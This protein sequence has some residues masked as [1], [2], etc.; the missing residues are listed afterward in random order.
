MIDAGLLKLC[1]LEEL[2]L[3][4]N[5]L[6]EVPSE[7]LPPR[8]TVL[9]LRN[10][11][12]KSLSA[13]TSHPPPRLLY[14]GL[15]SNPLGSLVDVS[16]LTGAHWPALVCLDLSCCDFEDQ[17]VLLGGLSSLPR[18]RSLLLEGTPCSLSRSYPGLTLDLLQQLTCLDQQWISP[19]ERQSFRGMGRLSGRDAVREC[20]R[21]TVHV[22]RLRG[23]PDPRQDRD[24]G[25]DFPLL[26]FSYQVSYD[27]ISHA[28][29]P[30]SI[31]SESEA[32]ADVA[33]ALESGQSRE[34]EDPCVLSSHSSSKLVWSESM[35]FSDSHSHSVWDLR[36]L[37]SFLSQGMCVRV[38]EEKILSWP[39]VSEDTATPKPGAKGAKAKD[40]PPTPA[41]TKGK[42]KKKRAV[43]ELVQDPPVRRE[44]GSLHVPLHSLLRRGHK[45][46]LCC[47]FGPLHSG[48]PTPEHATGKDEGKKGKKDKKE[49][50][51]KGESAKKTA[52][53][54]GKEKSV[55][56]EADVG[57]SGPQ[58][59]L[60]VELSVQLE[61]W[62]STAEVRDELG[63][64]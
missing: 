36:T 8:L 42:E 31:R 28:H 47:D 16:S 53:A 35:D 22:G 38:H 17:R 23:L 10:N 4:A 26:S 64:N 58:E 44:L 29:Q 11:Q 56:E 57:V 45:V 3:S 24:Q 5:R 43:P 40:A 15:A 12:V 37:K 21:A 6:T 51:K 19:E 20:A 54:K 34:A 49:E 7:L 55:K 48:T 30:Q 39:A 27:F 9:E 32:A 14:L 13:L 18:L 62:Q 59:P 33:D 1:N 61:R 46:A 41:P 60:T 50:A 52:T 2:V 25:Q 63:L